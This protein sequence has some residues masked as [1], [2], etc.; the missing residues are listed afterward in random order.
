MP[1]NRVRICPSCK[2]SISVTLGPCP[3]CRTAA[4]DEREERWKEAFGSGSPRERRDNANDRI[5]RA[6]LMALLVGGTL[7]GL[8][9]DGEA[10]RMSQTGSMGLVF[11]ML[12]A[13]LVLV[14]VALRRRK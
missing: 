13:G 9:Y 6:G 11:A 8:T 14:A 1:R 2:K 4:V 10:G 5:L 3:Y 12:G 7:A